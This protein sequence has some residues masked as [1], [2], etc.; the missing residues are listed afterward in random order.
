ME[1]KIIIIAGLIAVALFFLLR[2]VFT[3]YWKITEIVNNQSEQ[4]VILN[5]I[6]RRLT[7]IEELEVTQEEDSTNFE[8]LTEKENKL[9]QRFI[10]YGLKEG[11]RV[12]I[13]NRT[14]EI[15]RFNSAE[16]NNVDEKDEWKLLIEA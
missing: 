12:V 9:V 14:R 5:K 4:T 8:G 11:E 13:N 15:T 3:W 6:L 1:I 2:E 7:P 16:W 10:D